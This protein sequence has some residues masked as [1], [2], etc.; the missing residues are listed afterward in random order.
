MNRLRRFLLCPVLALAFV[1][2]GC[3][4]DSGKLEAKNKA[5]LEERKAFV[6]EYM[7]TGLNKKY[8]DVLGKSSSDE[9][10]SVYDLS[11][12]QNQAWFNRGTYPAKA[13]CILDGYAGEFDV[14]VYIE[15]NIKSF[16]T[17]KDSFYGILYGDEVRQ[18][19]EE[20]VSGYPLTEINIYYLPSEDI[21]KE[22]TELRQNLYI[23]G[24]YHVASDEELD[25]LCGLIDE[26]NTLGYVHRISIHDDIKG[27]RSMGKNNIT[28]DEVRSFFCS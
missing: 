17:F 5:E 28:S 9:L 25:E 23:F 18:S 10:F 20:L 7:K 24:V 27:N 21:V 4:Y 3:F 13:G 6:T 12:G 15:S 26:L 8:S 2:S 16:G 11:K 19:L 14:E 22:E 1:L